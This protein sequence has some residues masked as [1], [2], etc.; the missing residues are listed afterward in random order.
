MK[1]PRSL[2][3]DLADLVIKAAVDAAKKKMKKESELT[4]FEKYMK[5]INELPD[6]PGHYKPIE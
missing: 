6:I 1:E 2:E 4:P 3:E 5:E